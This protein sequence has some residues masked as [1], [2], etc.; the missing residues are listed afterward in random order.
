MRELS[1]C[2]S[3][4]WEAHTYTCADCAQPLHTTGHCR[5]ASSCTAICVSI[6]ISSK[7]VV[8]AEVTS[9]IEQVPCLVGALDVLDA[10]N[11]QQRIRAVIPGY[12]AC[13]IVSVH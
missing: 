12:A 10:R 13:D 5:I 4:I 8:T 2:V 6:I 9:I 7:S 3:R 1:S 11:R